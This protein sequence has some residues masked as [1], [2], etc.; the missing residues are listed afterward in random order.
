MKAIAV[1]NNKG[2][3]G[4]TTTVA[5]LGGSLRERGYFV[6]LLDTDPQSC[7][8][9]LAPGVEQ[10][11]PRDLPRKLRRLGG[12][13]Y[14]L[15]DTPPSLDERVQTVVRAVD[16]VVVPTL[17]EYLAL[18]GL[19]N[20]MAVVEPG[21][22]IGFVVVAYRGHVKH[23]R[24]VL[25]KIKGFGYP[26]LATVPFSI[27]ASDAGLLGKD[28]VAYSPAESRGV[29]AAYRQLAKEIEAWA[30]QVD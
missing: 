28:V 22:V 2:G 1:C 14:I 26:V 19:S 24:R 13:D 6:A 29:S 5:G 4:K 17:A 23:H 30:K 27:A 21:K 16:G 3:V 10:V 18:R 20:L 7:L 9:L 8:S 11:E 25:E 15:V 12:H